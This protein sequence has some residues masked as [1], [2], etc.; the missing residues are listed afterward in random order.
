MKRALF[1][2]AAVSGL[3]AASLLAAPVGLAA[4]T[5]NAT[6]QHVDDFQLTDHTRM[7]E[8]LYYYAYTP[9]IVVMSRT[10]SSAYSKQ[11]SA[12]LEIFPASQLRTL[13]R[14]TTT[15]TVDRAS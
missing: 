6:P 13:L 10:N 4:D 14:D 11:A 8:H 5:P 9:A 7:A 15:Y 2:A 12:A 3:A 1:A